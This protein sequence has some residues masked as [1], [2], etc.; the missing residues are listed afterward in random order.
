MVYAV[1]RAENY[2]TKVGLLIRFSSVNN[3]TRSGYRNHP[4]AL[5][6]SVLV[7]TGL[8]LF[9]ENEKGRTELKQEF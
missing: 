9:L 4:D 3:R 1:A 6:I 5:D 8:S 2:H 7:A